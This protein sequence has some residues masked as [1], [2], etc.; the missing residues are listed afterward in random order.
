MGVTKIGWCSFIRCT[1]LTSIN[2]P[3]SITTIGSSAFKDCTNITSIKVEGM[4]PPTIDKSTFENIDKKVCVLHIPKGSKE[5]YRNAQH[6]N[7]F[8]NVVEMV[9]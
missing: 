4:T 9:E 5:A 3:S 2:F 8:Q 1:G 6:W 7:E